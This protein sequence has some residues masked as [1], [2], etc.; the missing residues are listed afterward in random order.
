MFLS[1]LLLADSSR[2]ALQFRIVPGLLSTLL[3]AAGLTG[4]GETPAP[5]KVEDPAQQQVNTEEESRRKLSSAIQRIQPETMA[6]QTRRE[7]VVNSLNSWL[8]TSAE[9]DVEKIKIS[10]QNSAALSPAALRT[11]TAVRYT[12]NDIVYIRDCLLMKKLTE[13]VWKQADSISTSGQAS[14]QER[15]VA[16]FRHLMRNMSLLQADS[17]RIPVGLY[18]AMLTGIGSVDDRVRAFA[19]ALRQR[20]LDS[21]VLQA[22]T[23]GDPASPD[24]TLAADLLIGVVVDDRLLLFDPLRATA[25]PKPG[26]AGAIVTDPA[27]LEAIS[28]QDRW[29]TGSAFVVCHP[30]AFAPRMLILQERLEAS[31]SAILYEELVGGTSEIRPLTERLCTVVGSV[32]KPDALKVWSVPEQRIAAAAALSEEQKQAYTLL[33]RPLDSPFERESLNIGNLLADP[34]V[35]EAELTLEKKMEA[36]MLAL[37]KLLERSDDLFGKPSRGL[38]TARVQQIMGNFDIEMIQDLQGIRIACMQEKI[39]LEVPI[40]DKKAAV[41]PFVL[42]KTILDV[43]RSAVG[44]TLY[45]TS[46]S[47]LSRN[48]MGAAVATL[49]SYRRQYPDEKSF[50]ASLINEAEAL[51][52]LGDLKSAAVALKEA[53]VDKSP[54]RARAQWMLNRLGAAAVPAEAPP[55]ENPASPEK[56]SEPTPAEP[57]PAE[58]P[59]EKP[60]ADKPVSEPATPAESKSETPAAESPGPAETDPAATSN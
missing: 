42:P 1:H 29:K 39:E 31:D 58:P 51:I 23:P 28:N 5:V 45:W 55:A 35:N 34:T 14:E 49:R 21:I 47:Q 13:S 7:M 27:G 46:M 37:E 2:S 59:A 8:A 57:K 11:A 44:D 48:D 43:Q 16:L 17:T 24:I 50:Y 41:V 25:V 56:P 36:K 3:L 30:S 22:A 40:D 19:E 4:C 54:D 38:L 9:S 33:M 20:S 12:E 18:E 10:E 60:E 53:D 52:T 15:I 6:T 32:W 26:D